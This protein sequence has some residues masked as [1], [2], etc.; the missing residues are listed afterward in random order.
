MWRE[1]WGF[2]VEMVMEVQ[3]IL[4]LVSLFRKRISWIY[5]AENTFTYD[6]YVFEK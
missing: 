2:P 3:I 5:V 4:S 1:I 6:V